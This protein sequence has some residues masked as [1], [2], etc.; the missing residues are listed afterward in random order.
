ME[1]VGKSPV[2]VMTAE[3]LD[4]EYSAQDRMLQLHVK[5]VNSTAINNIE[6]GTSYMAKLAYDFVSVLM[7]S[8]DDVI[9]DIDVAYSSLDETA[10]RTRAECQGEELKIVAQL[11]G[12]YMGKDYTIQL[13]KA[14]ENQMQTQKKLSEE[15]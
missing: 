10:N 2:V 3:Q 14:L 8:Y 12:K 5:N 9:Q 4:G 7:E 6:S 1:Q 11:Y 15:T 13:K